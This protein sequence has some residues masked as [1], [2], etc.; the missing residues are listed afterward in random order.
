[1]MTYNFPRVAAHAALD[2]LITRKAFASTNGVV[3][4]VWQRDDRLILVFDPSAIAVE[5]VNDEFVHILSS[6]LHGRRVVRTNTRGM[7]IQIAYDIPK[8]PIQLTAQPLD[9]AAQPAPWSVPIGITAKGPLWISLLD[10][11]S[12]LMGGSTGNGKTGEE[13]AWIQSLLH[14]GKTLVYAQDGKQGAEFGRYLGHPNFHLITDIGA[15][16]KNL[17][18][19]FVARRQQLLASGHA[20]IT[21]HND[22]GGDFI[23]PIALF[24]D[25]AADVPDE[26]KPD[27]VGMIRLCR[28][29]GLYPI[30]TTNQPTQAAMFAK[31]NLSTRIAFRVPHHNDSIT[32]LGYKG[33]ESL[34]DQ[35][36]RG[37]IVWK[38]SII[39]FQSFTVT[40]PMPSQAAMKSLAE[41]IEPVDEA[42]AADK[43]DDI[44]QK[45][46]NA[47]LDCISRFGVP[48]WNEIERV[49]YN[50]VRGGSFHN[51]IKAVV[52]AFEG[53]QVGGNDE[54]EVTTTITNF[55]GSRPDFAP[56]GG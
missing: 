20:N 3:F 1:M 51:K 47:Y 5:K 54:T 46:I 28:Y 13:H 29:L 40:Y 53:A 44:S 41:R 39:E 49:V 50:Q 31:T 32:I 27:L 11:V 21:M 33:A 34:S 2:L 24:M 17:A 6:R 10:G 15:G 18:N 22:A 38:G 42:P 36:G 25:E 8:A 35:R 19:I 55:P 7:F 37:L 16:L 48:K 30:V 23:M 52:S 14:G 45:I 56:A 9:L 43:P 12:F 4:Y 26:S